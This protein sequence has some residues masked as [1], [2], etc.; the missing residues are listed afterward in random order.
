MNCHSQTAI[1][2]ENRPIML[3]RYTLMASTND[4]T[5][6][7]IIIK[8]YIKQLGFDFNETPLDMRESFSR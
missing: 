2:D 3:L 1:I 7:T 6:F 8:I 5:L 4:E